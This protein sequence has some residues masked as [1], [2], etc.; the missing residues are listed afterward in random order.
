MLLIFCTLSEERRLAAGVGGKA[1]GLAVV[2]GG[3]VELSVAS[4]LRS[5]ASP[6]GEAELLGATSKSRIWEASTLF[7][8]RT[9]SPHV[10]I[11]F[12]WMANYWPN[13]SQEQL[14]S[15]YCV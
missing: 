14:L 2:P 6:N 5:G 8:G 15:A 4:P 12:H 1:E 7:C 13:K 9:V 3:R 11:F 10:M